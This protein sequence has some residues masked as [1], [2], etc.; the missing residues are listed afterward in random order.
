MTYVTRLAEQRGQPSDVG[1]YPPCVVAREQLCCRSLAGVVLEIDVGQRLSVSIPHDDA[2]VEFFDGPWRWEAAGH[3]AQRP[4][5][6]LTALCLTS[7]SGSDAI[8]ANAIKERRRSMRRSAAKPRAPSILR[9]LKPM[10]GS[11]PTGGAAVNPAPVVHIR[12]RTAVI[13]ARLDGAAKGRSLAPS[14]Q[15]LDPDHVTRAGVLF[16]PKRAAPSLSASCGAA[17]R[18]TDARVLDDA[19][20]LIGD[21]NESQARRGCPCRAVIEAGKLSHFE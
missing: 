21:W 12:R 7:H 6:A 1:S 19:E 10:A 20:R 3:D 9:L 11:S 5:Y 8:S 2:A 13:R 17:R 15:T 4:T 18:V 16:W 14:S